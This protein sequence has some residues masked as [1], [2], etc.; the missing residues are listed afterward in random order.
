MKSLLIKDSK[1]RE[2]LK[3]NEKGQIAAG[4]YPDLDKKLKSYVVKLY[5]E[6]TG[7]PKK[8]VL[9]FLNYRTEENEFCS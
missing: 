8:E 3:I 5:S 1:G 2:I 7:K 4:R 9:A 6:L